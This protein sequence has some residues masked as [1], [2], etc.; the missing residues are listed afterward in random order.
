MTETYPWAWY[1]DPAVLER[2]RERIFRPA[3]HYV[4]HAGSVAEPS[5]YFACTTGGLPVIVTR[6]RE[7]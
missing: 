3:W 1:S 2:E 4:G 6:D 5:S 7:R